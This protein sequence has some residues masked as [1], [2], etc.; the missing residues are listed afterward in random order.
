M[1]V[2]MAPMKTDKTVITARASSAPEN[3]VSREYFIAI[4]AAIKK[5]LSPSSETKITD[6]LDKNP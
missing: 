3:I 2:V 1:T 6:K 4:M 5:V